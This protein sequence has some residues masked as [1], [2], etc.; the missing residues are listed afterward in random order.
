MFHVEHHAVFTR[1]AK[2]ETPKR[3]DAEKNNG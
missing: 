2:D 3:G 1:E